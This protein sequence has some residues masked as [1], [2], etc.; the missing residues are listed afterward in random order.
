MKNINNWSKETVKWLD[1]FCFKNRYTEAEKFVI[2]N[3]KK[4][5]RDAKILDYGCGTGR[6]AEILKREIPDYNFENYLGVDTSED[7]IMVAKE[8]HPNLNFSVGSIEELAE[9]VD[10]VVSL[11]V[12]QHQED[13][14]AFI[15][16]LIPYYKKALFI[17]FWTNENGQNF[18]DESKEITLD[19]TKEKF[20]E[21]IYS[22]KAVEELAEHFNMLFIEYPNKPNN[23]GLLFDLN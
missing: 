7:M 12:L 23:I 18:N 5:P 16:S 3:I 2:A 4:L 10:V 15:E 14:V 8:K 22:K 9:Q 21:N 19:A 20:F 6:F 17:E 11:D 1:E 13:G